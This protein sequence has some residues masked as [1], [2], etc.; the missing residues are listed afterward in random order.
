MPEI[1]TL[2][3]TPIYGWGWVG[4]P[5]EYTRDTP[6]PFHLLDLKQTGDGWEGTVSTAGHEFYGMIAQFSRRLVGWDGV[7]NLTLR[8]GLETAGQ[9][10][11][12]VPAS[13][14]P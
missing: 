9:G 10:W 7:V 2:T 1:D 5:P 6:E 3:M 8:N 11:G 12:Q 14:V 4:S 13:F